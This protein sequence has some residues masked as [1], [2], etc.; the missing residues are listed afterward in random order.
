MAVGR[1]GVAAPG[2]RARGVPARSRVTRRRRE[3]PLLRSATLA[4]ALHD[5][6]SALARLEGELDALLA[7]LRDPKRRPEA[8]DADRLS[9]SVRAADAAVAAL[10][11]F[12]TR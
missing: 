5:S 8:E 3:A 1:R 9:G 4:S 10:S 6:R 12:A 11:A 7:S 2:S